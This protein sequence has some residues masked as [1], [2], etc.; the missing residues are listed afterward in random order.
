MT[1]SKPLDRILYVDDDAPS[2]IQHFRALGAVEVITKP[3]N[4]KTFADVLRSIWS[5]LDG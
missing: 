2:E 4:P 5:R 1:T 3:F